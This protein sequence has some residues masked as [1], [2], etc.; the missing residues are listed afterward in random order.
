MRTIGRGATQQSS[1]PYNRRVVLDFIRQQGAASRKDIADMVSLSP[2]TVANITNELEAIGL[3]VSRR[4]KVDKSRGQPPIAF[5]LNPQAGHSIGISLEPGRASAAL[6]NLVGEI[7]HRCEVD[8]DTRD[9]QQMFAT[10]LQLVARL[11]RE[12]TDRLWGIGIALPGPLGHTD[13]S[14]VGPTALEGW[15]DLSVLEELG[16]A[17]GLPLF[18]RIDS[19]AGALG[20]TLFGV[21]R[22]LDDFFYLHLGL[23][24]GGALVI[25]RSAY[26][27]ANGNATEIGHV[28]AV[29]GGTPCYCGNRGCLERYVSMHSLAEA[30]EV[31]DHDVWSLDLAQRLRDPADEALHRW[32]RQA[33]DR[34]RDAVCMIE[35]M[36]DPRA[37]VIGGS[38]PKVL[39]EHLVALAQ[40][41]HRS[42]RGGVAEPG[43]RL[44][45]SDRQDDSSLLGA[46][47]L[48]L[49]EMLSPRLEVLQQD[50]RGSLDAA[51]LL[52]N[53]PLPRR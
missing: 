19:V 51:E 53:K 36:L 30:L 23:G 50:R 4:Q 47:V 22:H 39:V 5:E 12:A 11:R 46:A 10:L 37:I 18:H 42:V 40:P 31:S 28:P 20:E 3:I 45:L 15:T 14:F 6:V 33:A 52:G 8:I 32:C 24:L 34:L 48:P 26:P 13:I 35:N 29:P 44:L 38:A 43:T 1:A 49:Y 21:A 41:W 27:G 25:G 16:E 9:R 2:Q 7:Q 17:T